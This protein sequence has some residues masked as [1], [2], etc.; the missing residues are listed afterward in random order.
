M[1]T[2]L[3]AT[4]LACLAFVLQAPIHGQQAVTVETFGGLEFYLQDANFVKDLKLTPDQ[5]NKAR[6]TSRQIKEKHRAD[7]AKLANVPKEEFPGKFEELQKTVADATIQALGNVLKPEQIK[8]LKQLELQKRGL[9]LFRDAEVEKQLKLTDD[10][11]AKIKEIKETT[12]RELFKLVADAQGNAAKTQAVFQKRAG[13]DKENLE[14]AVALLN[15]DQKKVW[16][17]LVG[18]LFEFK[19]I[20]G[21][22][23]K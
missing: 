20:G 22:V 19:L 18:E 2:L 4:L 13:I 9:Q 3:K 8:R 6:V 5:L 14:K 11:K 10:Q 17:E 12:D 7:M 21:G 1:R 23:L 15:E 16:K